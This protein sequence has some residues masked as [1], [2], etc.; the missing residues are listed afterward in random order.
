M[1]IAQSIINWMA[2]NVWSESY[3]LI[4]QTGNDGFENVNSLLMTQR[5]C[6][7]PSRITLC[8]SS[9]CETCN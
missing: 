2:S 4:I 7:A 6:N 9:L 8:V 5:S 1:F 3:F